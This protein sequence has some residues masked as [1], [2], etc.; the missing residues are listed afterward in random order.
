MRLS[1]NVG[2]KET[3]LFQLRD[4][5]GIDTFNSLYEVSPNRS[6]FMRNFIRKDGVNHKR[7]GWKCDTMFSQ[8]EGIF[9]FRLY[10]EQEGKDVDK[11]IV[12]TTTGFFEDVGEGEGIYFSDITNSCSYEP[13]TIGELTIKTPE[14]F[15]YNNKA[16]F[17]GCGEYLVYGKYENNGY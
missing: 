4:F 14:M 1:T 10:D 3:K 8:I 15:V 7:N 5:L 11:L 13:A 2:V 12:C 9:S 17:V 16:Y 6:T